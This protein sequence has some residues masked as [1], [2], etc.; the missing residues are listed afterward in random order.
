MTLQELEAEIR[1]EYERRCN[2]TSV[3]FGEKIGLEVVAGVP[4]GHGVLQPTEDSLNWVVPFVVRGTYFDR[5]TGAKK[6]I[7]YTNTHSIEI[8]MTLDAVKVLMEM[9]HD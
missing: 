5:L 6:E 8:P 1:L 2:I 7:E 3:E 9:Q 4:E